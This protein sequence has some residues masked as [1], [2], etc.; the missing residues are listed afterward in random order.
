MAEGFKTVYNLLGNS[1]K[2]KGGST[3]VLEDFFW[4]Q[5]IS[6]TILA[7][8]VLN[9]TVEFLRGGGIF[10]F[11]LSN[12]RAIENQIL[13]GDTKYEFGPGQTNYINNYCARIIFIF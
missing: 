10:C 6:S 13:Q 11:P 9:V 8:T 7:L 1:E 2:K 4:D 3:V 5:F 12:N